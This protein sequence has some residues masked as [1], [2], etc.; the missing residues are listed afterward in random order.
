MEWEKGNLHSF[1]RHYW[2][3]TK[4]KSGSKW[5]LQ[6]T[7]VGFD[8]PRLKDSFEHDPK[9][10]GVASSISQLERFKWRRIDFQSEGHQKECLFSVIHSPGYSW[11]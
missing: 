3:I 10:G 9:Y 1:E 7:F 5:K 4:W 2:V 6:N 8:I 11:L